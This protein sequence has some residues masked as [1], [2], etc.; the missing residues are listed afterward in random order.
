MA[1]DA[2]SNGRGSPEDAAWLVFDPKET[3]K[4]T[5]SIQMFGSRSFL[6]F[7][8][9]GYEALSLLDDDRDGSIVGAELTGL[10]LWND[11]NS[12]GISDPG[13][14][15]PVADH[16]ISALSARAQKHSSG[17]PYAPEGVT[18]KDGT[19]RPTYDLILTSK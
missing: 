18:F 10:A 14:V 7:C 9:D 6:L 15:K 3:G 12:N 1:Q 17:M 11:R 16:G 2:S 13:E 5:S 4:I 19:T 8:S